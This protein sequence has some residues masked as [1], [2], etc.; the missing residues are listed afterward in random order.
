MSTYEKVKKELSSFLQKN[1]SANVEV[2]V[3]DLLEEPPELNLGEFALPCFQLA[4]IQKKA[5]PQIASDLEETLKS[6]PHP[7]VEKFHAAGPYLNIK[8]KRSKFIKEVLKEIEESGKDYGKCNVGKNH[9]VVID[10]SSPNIAK[11]LAFHHLRSAVIGN[12]L[13]KIFEK[14]GY[15]VIGINHLGDWGTQFGKLIC[16]YKLWWKKGPEDLTVTDLNNLYVKF[17]QECKT[18]KD[19]IPEGRNWFKKLEQG[20]EEAQNLW[21]IFREKSLVEFNKIYQRLGI[22]FDETKGEADYIRDVPRILELLKKKKLSQNS[23][24]ALIVDLSDEDMPP[25]LLKKSDESTLYAT[26]D[27][28]AAIDRYEKHNF[29]RMLYVV[30]TGQS[31]HF[32]Q[33][34]SVLNRMKFKWAPLCEHVN[35]GIIKF[36]GTKTRTREGNIILLE[37][38]LDEA[39]KQIEKIMLDRGETKLLDQAQVCEQIGIGA[40]IFADLSGRR[41]RDVNFDWDEILKFEGRTGPY[42]QYS[43]ARANSILTKAN[44]MDEADQ[45]RFLDQKETKPLTLDEEWQIVWNLG[46]YPSI[47]KKAANDCEPSYIADNLLDIC[48]SFHRYHTK[49]KINRELRVLTENQPTRLARMYLTY[50]TREVLKNGLNVLGIHAPEVM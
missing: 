47:L 25:F 22:Q 1:L 35:F 28:C 30:D 38:V 42:I 6:Q 27:L 44:K 5:P 46:K 40:V 32:R 11:H 50:C 13:E 29:V 49:G 18:N 37:E 3:N 31:L 33:L 20:D 9:T 10:Y 41:I 24:G 23:E 16:A 36:E 2:P 39:V 8:L 26:R 17:Q 45:T 15:N 21:K 19:L 48:E 7:W 14:I 4:K 43:H 12:A 34:F